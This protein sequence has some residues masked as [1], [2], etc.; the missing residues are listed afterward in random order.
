M[1]GTI[2]GASIV[3][4]G[5]YGN[6][7][8]IPGGAGVASSSY[9]LVNNAVVPLN[10]TVPATWTVA[11][12]INTITVGG[13]YLTQS[14]AGWANANTEFY[15]ENGIAGDP[16]TGSFVGGVRFAQGWES[17]STIVNDGNWH[18]IVMTCTNA[19]KTI[20]VDGV[21]DPFFVG[22]GGKRQS[23]D[24]GWRGHSITDWRGFAGSGQ[25][26]RIW[27]PY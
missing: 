19:V 25:P 21:L 16:G 4:G 22:A 17:G 24:W 10:I 6:A 27:R 3:P 23:M 14:S 8:S 7:L 20:Y 12:W 1:N 5:R 26:G 13:A 18:F 11:M 2:V 15:L 9:V